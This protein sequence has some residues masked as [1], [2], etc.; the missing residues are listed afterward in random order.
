MRRVTTLFASILACL[1]AVS[2]FAADPL[3]IKDAKKFGKTL[4]A[5]YDLPREKILKFR[6]FKPS[7]PDKDESP[8]ANALFADTEP[9][10]GPTLKVYASSNPYTVAVTISGQV[11][12]DGA[13]TSL[14]QVG[15]NMEDGASRYGVL[16]GPGTTKGRAGELVTLTTAATPTSFKDDR[17][18]S[19]SLG[20]IKTGNIELDTVKVQVWSGVGG[21]SWVEK[22]LSFQALLVAVVFFALIW[23]FRR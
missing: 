4:I 10:N 13:V 5:E 18:T 19:V 15:W 11:K 9:W 6:E 14:W 23:W 3:L 21:S 17:R 12:A 16:P 1:T 7:T 20:L 22:L 2:L 8:A